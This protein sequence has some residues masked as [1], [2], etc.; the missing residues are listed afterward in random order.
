MALGLLVTQVG[1]CAARFSPP[2]P[3]GELQTWGEAPSTALTPEGIRIVVWNVRKLNERGTTADLAS[4]ARGADL[5]LLQEAIDAP[6]LRD[7]GTPR[8]GRWTLAISFVPVRRGRHPTGVAIRGGASPATVAVVRSRGREPVTRTPKMILAQAYS[9][10]GCASSLLVINVHGLAFAR[11]RDFEEQLDVL[12]GLVE[13]HLGPVLLAGDFNT[14][15]AVRM[16]AL[17]GVVQRTG[18]ESVAFRP[19]G[20]R[21]FA[22]RPL[23]HAFVRDLVPRSARAPTDIRSSDHAPLLLEVAAR[24]VPDSA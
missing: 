4:L 8:A 2:P 20:R 17:D 22:G 12:R 18:M 1:G 5:L 7:L 6:A 13:N 11:R 10:H 21:R 3:G 23:D 14:W 15:S 24:C 19:D 16:R 9:L